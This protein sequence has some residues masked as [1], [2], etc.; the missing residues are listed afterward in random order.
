M[1]NNDI[2]KHYVDS[3]K[4]CVNINHFDEERKKIA[5]SQINILP[6]QLGFTNNFNELNNIK[7]AQSVLLNKEESK[8]EESKL[9][10]NIN[11]NKNNN[12]N[13]NE[14]EDI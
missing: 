8:I 3:I 14:I 2:L 6:K 7:M 12:E 9:N 1:S 5:V 4:Q 13:E 10:D 11:T